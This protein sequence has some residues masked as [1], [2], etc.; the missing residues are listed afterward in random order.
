M[1]AS[2]VTESFRVIHWQNE[3][4]CNENANP[5]Y[6]A[7]LLERAADHDENN[8]LREINFYKLGLV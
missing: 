7:I 5:S 3:W 6:R 4:D 2:E 1:G 8:G